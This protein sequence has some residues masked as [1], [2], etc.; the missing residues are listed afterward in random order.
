M[1]SA[2]VTGAGRGLGAAIAA[3]L[4]ARGYSVRVTDVDHEA[5]EQT[6]SSIGGGTTASELDV[7]DSDACRLL[8]AAVASHEG[9]LDLWVNN[10]GVLATGPSWTHPVGIRNAMV[11]VNTLGTINGT[12]G[13]LEV[14]RPAGRGHVINVVSLAGIFPTP[15]EAIYSASKHAALAF[16]LATSADLRAAGERGVR[17]SCLCPDGIWTPMLYP[18]LNDPT[19]AASF[20]GSM[21][22]TDQV[23]TALLTLVD[24]PKLVLAVP[25]SR[26]VIARLAA[27]FPR[28]LVGAAPAFLADG[29]RRQR[30]FA[31][32]LEDGK[33]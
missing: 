8:A 24:Q 15:G 6:A 11:Q 18:K 30:R 12:L 1:P 28:F 2:V 25:R 29:R 23:T 9:G 13:A 22:T 27:S 7:T 26:G 19:A 33:L 10:A 21:L 17:I 16:S 31:K 14:M 20:T 3:A 5:A 32:R 4:A